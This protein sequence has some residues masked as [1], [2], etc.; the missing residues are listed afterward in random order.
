[1]QCTAPPQQP[2]IHN[3]EG[4]KKLLV[5]ADRFG[6]THLKLY[7]ESVLVDRFA[8]PRNA[9]SLLLFADSHSC[10]LLKERAMDLYAEDPDA[11]V[12]ISSWTFVEESERIFSELSNHVHTGFRQNHF[13]K[14]KNNMND[15][16]DEEEDDLDQCDIFSIREHL[17]E[18]GLDAD[19]SRNTLL[20]R[21][22]KHCQ[23]QR[24]T[25][26]E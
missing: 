16:G 24:N 20:G 14:T 9:A 15:D 17:C 4:A 22:R 3:E 6:L 7:V 5:A 18:Y 8:T 12:A 2:P 21:L 10:A 26:N 25:G 1:M 23:R 19:G 13:S 11:V